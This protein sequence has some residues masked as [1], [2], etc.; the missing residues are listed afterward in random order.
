MTDRRA[1]GGAHG[2]GQNPVAAHP[3]GPRGDVAR[4]HGRR[5]D[6]VQVPDPSRFSPS[7]E[8]NTTYQR[9]ANPEP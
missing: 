5:A 3:H 2:G 8:L 7:M 9:F 1:G 6:E 4:A